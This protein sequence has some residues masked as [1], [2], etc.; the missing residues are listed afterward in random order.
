MQDLFHFC[1]SGHKFCFVPPHKYIFPEAEYF[2]WLKS[3]S[4]SDADTDSSL[5]SSRELNE[6]QTT[7]ESSALDDKVIDLTSDD[8]ED[9][10]NLKEVANVV[11][12]ADS[13]NSSDL[14]VHSKG[15][16][17]CLEV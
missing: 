10:Q 14:N 15:P 9:E 12:E 1:I 13:V 11:A 2:T 6:T 8:K 17:T 4:E 16:V 7:T 3:D 5:D